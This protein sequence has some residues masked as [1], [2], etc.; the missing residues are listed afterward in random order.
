MLTQKSVHGL[1][2]YNPITGWLTWRVP[3]SNNT[4]AGSRAGYNCYKD[5]TRTIPN[6]RM[7]RIDGQHYIETRIIW[8]WMTG[9]MPPNNI[10]IDHID[11]NRH[12]NRWANLR[13]A[14]SSEST[15]YRRNYRPKKLKWAYKDKKSGKYK[16]QTQFRG[17]VRYIGVFPTELEAH[18]AAH[19]V[20]QRLH[21]QFVRKA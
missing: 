7:V 12:N 1:F 15:A 13:L 10:E 5:K 14:T 11:F 20:A 4:P 17:I 6:C 9:T 16:A 21:G 19:A 18:N 3:A 8:L 2:N